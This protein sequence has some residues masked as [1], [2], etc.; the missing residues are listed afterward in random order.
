MAIRDVAWNTVED[1]LSS[2]EATGY[3]LGY[4][5]TPV[6]VDRAISNLDMYNFLLGSIRREDEKD[7]ELLKRLF[8]GLQ[9]V[10][11]TNQRKRESVKTLWDINT[12][13]NKYLTYMKNIVGW[14]PQYKYITDSLE[15]LDLRR[16][17]SLSVPLWKKRGPEAAILSLL[18]L[19]TGS[20]TRMFNWFD[21]RWVLGE[22]ESGVERLGTD[23]WIIDNPGTNSSEYYSNLRIVDDGSLDH[24][25]VREAVNL[26]RACGERI[27]VTYV[28]FMDLFEV[29]DDTSQ[30]IIDDPTYIN[31]II[32]VENGTM[33][34]PSADL[35]Y[36]G[37]GAKSLRVTYNGVTEPYAYQEPLFDGKSYRITGKARG[38]GTANPFIENGAG[39]TLWTG[40]SSVVWQSF[41][42]SFK[43]LA[44][45][46]RFVG[47]ST[48][49]GHVEF[50][51]VKIVYDDVILEDGNFERANSLLEDGDM[52]ADPGSDLV[53]NGNFSGWADSTVP[54]GWTKSGTHDANNYVEESSGGCR[55]VS[56]GTGISI[57]QSVVTV[58]KN[59]EITYDVVDVTSG[60]AKIQWGSSDPDKF[61]I[62]S[63]GSFK[64]NFT[65]N[66]I[67][68]YFA[69][70][71]ACDVT[72]DNLVIQE[73]AQAWTANDAAL[74]S[75]QNS[76]PKV[77]LRN[78]RVTY[79]GTFAPSASQDLL[80]VGVKYKL[81]GYYRG[82]G[83]SAIPRVRCGAPY[84][85]IGTSSNTWQAF[86]VTFVAEGDN[87][88]LYNY[89]S[90]G[91]TEFDDLELTLVDESLLFDH[92]M[93]REWGILEDGDCESLNT[94]SWSSSS[95]TLSK[96]TTDPK[97][98]RR[99]LRVTP[100]S[101]S[102]GRAKQNILISGKTYR[103][104]GWARTD[105]TATKKAAIS[106]NG[107]SN[108]VWEGT[109]AITTWEYFD[110]LFIAET[111]EIGF[112]AL[113][114]SAGYT[115]FDDLKVEYL[116]D[117]NIT[118]ADMEGTGSDVIK[119][120]DMEDFGLDIIS[121]GDMEDTGS[122]L[123]SDGN[124]EKIGTNI[125]L[126]GDMENRTDVIVDG[127]MENGPGSDVITNG[128]FAN[129]TGDDPDNWTVVG[130]TGTSYITENSPLGAQ[131]VSDG[132]NINMIQTAVMTVGK[133]Y[134]ISFDITQSNSGS[135]RLEDDGAAGTIWSGIS[136]VQTYS[137]KY[138]AKG[139]GIRFIRHVACD[140]TVDNLV[141]KES[142][143]DWTAGNSAKLTKEI[144]NPE[145]GTQC[146]KIEYNGSSSP[147]AN[148]NVLI[149]SKVFRIKGYARS[150]GTAIPAISANGFPDV[151]V[152]TNSVNWQYFEFDVT[153]TGNFLALENNSSSGYV[154]FDSVVVIDQAASCSNWTAGSGAVLTKEITN[155]QN[156]KQ[157]LRVTDSGSVGRAY[158]AVLVAGKTYRIKGYARS[159][160]TAT[161]T[162]EVGGIVGN[163]WTGTTSTS[164]QAFDFLVVAQ[165][166][167]LFL[168]K[169][170]GTGVYVEFD[171]VQAIESELIDGDMEKTGT[172]LITDGDMEAGPGSEEFTDG[173]MEAVGFTNWTVSQ[174]TGSKETSS[175]YEGS[176]WAKLTATSG[177]G[178]R[179]PQMYQGAL[180]IGKVYRVTGV[181]K[182]DGTQMARVTNA[183]GG[184][185]EDITSGTS[186]TPFDFVFLATSVSVAL[187]FVVTDPAG[188]EYVGYDD[189]SVVETCPDWIDGN[190]SLLTKETTTPYEG[191]QC[192]RIPYNGITNPFA[193]QVA[194]V[195]S[196]VY[197]VKGVVRSDGTT[198][199]RVQTGATILFTGTTS[200]SW[201]PFDVVFVAASVNFGLWAYGSSGYAEF[202]AIELF[203]GANAVSDWTPINNA[204]LT[205][206]VTSPQAGDQWLKIANSGTANPDAQ[207]SILTVGEVYRIKGYFKGDGTALPR[208]IQG[209]NI[210]ATG[211]TSTSWQSF[212]A[213][214]VAAVDTN[215]NFQARATVSPG[216]SVGFDSI[217]LINE[218]DSCSDWTVVNSAILSKQDSTPYEGERT[219]RMTYN[220]STSPGAEQSILTIGK[221]YRVKGVM[222]SSGV[223]TPSVRDLG[224]AIWNGT[225]STSW[226][227]FDVVF[228]AA[229]NWLRLQ[230]IGSSG[231]VEADN[232][233]VIDESESCDDWTVGNS[234]LLSKQEDPYS[235]SK[236]LRIEYDGSGYPNAYQLVM[237]VDKTYR[238][239][240]YYRGDGSSAQPR[241]YDT[242]A[243]A[244]EIVSGSFGSTWEAFDV[245]WKAKSTKLEFRN[246]SVVAGYVEFDAI[247]I[248]DESQSCVEWGLGNSALL[249]KQEDPYEGSQVLRVEYGGSSFPYAK[250]DIVTIDKTYRVRG[251]ARGDGTAL[252]KILLQDTTELFLGT[253]STSW[254]PF[255][256]V[257]KTSSTQAIFFRANT[258]SDSY[259]EFDAVEVIDESE[260]CDD[261]IV[262]NDAL[263][264]KEVTDPYGGSQNLKIAYNNESKPYA[265]SVDSI[266]S[267][268]ICR[269][270][271][272]FRTGGSGNAQIWSA[273][274]AVNWSV[275]DSAGN[276]EWND[277]IYGN[278]IFV[279]VSRTSNKVATS[280]D[281]I[282]WTL[283]TGATEL[284]WTDVAYGNGTFVAVA[285]SGTNNRVMTS[286][287]GISWTSRTSAA[288]NYW[289]SVTYG[290]GIFVAVAS[291]GTGNR[292]MTSIDGTTWISR[293]AA[294]DNDWESVTF[295]N[296]LFVAVSTN[297]SSNR[298][299]TSTNGTSWTSRTSAA[300]NGWYSV[301]YGNG[302]YVAV[303]SSGTGNRVMTSIDGTTWISRNA[304]VDN[305]WNDVAYGNGL[306]VAV[307]RTGT[308]DRMMSSVD[309]TT[310][311]TRKNSVDGD[312]RGV[313]YGNGTFVTVAGD[314]SDNI[315]MVSEAKLVAETS[316]STWTE[317]DEEFTSRNN[318]IFMSDV[319][320]AGYAEF[321]EVVLKNINNDYDIILDG[322]F[323]R[324]GTIL[325]DGDLEDSGISDWTVTDCA[326]TKE[327][328][329]PYRGTRY[330]RL[331]YNGTSSG[332]IY[333]DLLKF[334]QN[335]RIK[336]VARGDGVSNPR[337]SDGVTVLWTGT[338]STNWQKFNIPFYKAVLVNYLLFQGLNLGTGNYVEFDDLELISEETNVLEDGDMELSDTTK[339]GSSSATL[340]KNAT[341]HT[342][343]YCLRIYRTGGTLGSAYAFQQ[344]LVNGARYRVTGWARGNTLTNPSVRCDPGTTLW[345]GTS[346]Q[347][348]QYFDEIFVADSVVL[349]FYK[350]QHATDLTG[351]VEFDNIVVTQVGY[352]MEW[353]V[354]GSGV[355]LSKKD[356]DIIDSTQCL[357]I[358]TTTATG[359]ASQKIF[360][361]GQ[362]YRVRG[363]A[364][365]DGTAIPSVSAVGTGSSE[366]VGD[367]STSWQEFDFLTKAEDSELQLINSSTSGYVE[368]DKI[369]VDVINNKIENGDFTNWTDPTVPDDWD[370]S[371][372]HD[373]NNYVI[374]SSG[375]CRVV[376]DGTGVGIKQDVLVSGK[377]YILTWDVTDITTDG[378]KWS[379]PGGEL[380]FT[381]EG[382]KKAIIK[383]TGTSLT[384]YRRAV[385]V[386]ADFTIDNVILYEL[387]DSVDWT[388]GNN[389]ILTKQKFDAIN[390]SQ[391]IKVQYGGTS[392]PDAVQFILT[393]GE[394]YRVTG[395]YRCDGTHK[396]QV[397]HGINLI[398]ETLNTSWTY[399]DE[400]FTS[401]SSYLALFCNTSVSGGWAEFDDIKVI[402]L[403]F[404]MN[405][406]S[407]NDATITKEFS[408]PYEGIQNLKVAY[409]GTAN[410][411]AY[412][413]K[414]FIT[415]KQYR[416]R[417]YFRGDGSS[418]YAQILWGNQGS[419][420]LITQST[421]SNTWQY[422]DKTFT[423]TTSGHNELQLKVPISA[424]GY[425]EFD[426]IQV[427][428]LDPIIEDGDM[429]APGVDVIIDGDMEAV[430][431]AAWT[432]I[433]SVLTK[434]TTEP[435]EGSQCLRVTYSSSGTQRAEQQVTTI[436][437]TY[438]I[439]GVAR[440][441]GIHLPK[442]YENGVSL[443]TGNT[444]TS[445]Q[446]FDVIIRAAYTP[447][448]I[449]LG[450]SLS[451]G[452]VEFDDV[453]IIDTAPAWDS[454]H[455]AILTKSVNVLANSVAINHL[456][457]PNASV[458]ENYLVSTK[459][460]AGFSAT[461]TDRRWGIYLYQD[462]SSVVGGYWA[463]F[464]ILNN[465]VHLGY[466]DDPAGVT[467]N[468][469]DT[470]GMR[471]AKDVY[472]GINIEIQRVI[473]SSIQYII[474]NLFIDG[475][476]I[477]TWKDVAQAIRGRIAFFNYDLDLT[478]EDVEVAKMPIVVETIDINS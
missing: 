399:F 437:K 310:W 26:M 287:D 245:V 220:A 155:P 30:W 281:G 315:I 64:Y 336:G 305:N 453:K 432:A 381:T 97:I 264:S 323:D 295:G 20:R 254:Q 54:D 109:E 218:T 137:T 42:V 339:W 5:E 253:T 111:A 225:T 4:S 398:T 210:L 464:D 261:L 223:M 385:S 250:Q 368:F 415:N 90:A 378:G 222:R 100:S 273:S 200:T 19:V 316:N 365:S 412:Q 269:V 169:D 67:D 212:D 392:R 340:E 148:Q 75:K 395:Y 450:S 301:T 228:V 456:V 478:I 159:D 344:E 21:F 362:Y 154:E 257:F 469:L 83:S 55:L 186:W 202:D 158:Q 182:S 393:N 10:W 422:F 65:A 205:K 94:T 50:D 38:D 364:R 66:R 306:F 190:S 74:L 195:V 101:S 47:S 394:K 6:S 377:I 407:Y 268:K 410:P 256:V 104:T 267:G 382:S 366:W 105:G 435:Y 420:T 311:T 367:T 198:I 266:P 184:L 452:Y 230:G 221:T 408:D 383:P 240:G 322:N 206:E 380:P 454:D 430:G 37:E 185:S 84:I 284:L 304:A 421:T 462:Q 60:S 349:R 463:I 224:T 62:N 288:D 141:I 46:I 106:P 423:P 294:V 374:E 9:K 120:G 345:T 442:V 370:K 144:I 203:D 335:Y 425:A 63:T 33:K 351:Y 86:D 15:P 152:G 183:G 87:I 29:N 14:T 270:K 474:I 476:K 396:A 445:W 259:V 146:L 3:M 78:L 465:E 231:Y 354:A 337:I 333:Q 139:T 45:E 40:T 133:T 12:I 177:A 402:P 217:E 328:G 196:N 229:T 216:D 41:D 61:I 132:S 192:L 118:D 115:E 53:T 314:S 95:A 401:A 235:G 122:D 319:S 51:D 143:P 302:L 248:I 468:T 427:E 34:I 151:W 39:T 369:Q 174:A 293:N 405:W 214:F 31:S 397:Q 145:N 391:S 117:N 246:Q 125:V 429:E 334:G 440:S 376:S 22:T 130:E 164:W 252:P 72:I 279:A 283:R 188:T 149:A 372:T 317:F 176:Q 320:A 165:G 324:K 309:G 417:G 444:S 82:D 371:G 471:L 387:P 96:Q 249:S 286:T 128:D 32:T 116:G 275:R 163:L 296:D 43:S 170:P 373:V 386:A 167:N 140:V 473:E 85:S 330:V 424:S 414:V 441:D 434:E 80:T 461:G 28:S 112:H 251:V 357:R 439:T 390:G 142:C 17:I 23:P 449:Q 99:Y 49:A 292:V 438:R 98:G 298:V 460:K 89:S 93:E 119:D 189:V 36:S 162:V 243:G 48:A 477:A 255:D 271:G 291:S 307:A 127:D 443:W 285:R 265:I 157:C 359:T 1:P 209:G 70:N 161:P 413:D 239:R 459:T 416:I 147:Y 326:L 197:R 129:W 446:P 52:E 312:F 363:L 260:S 419:G 103:I 178:T 458:W 455:S 258:A 108:Y 126:D 242:G 24:R 300:D 79:G 384:L 156:G 244:Y 280:T 433:A 91:Y 290:N 342:G 2:V 451:G 325:K 168:E 180:T 57:F 403:G 138:V 348:W 153:P 44:K 135:I 11:D 263:L 201:Q 329:S 173:D 114:T 237:V 213:V 131:I 409:N 18:R 274:D 241:I 358:T 8:T 150:D 411:I 56:D 191:T 321:D 406:V 7:T 175:P 313:A 58:G 428:L 308:K 431:V 194:T 238:I 457:I 327:T 211:T 272:H 247:E 343:N 331:T 232:V 102:N 297:G 68:I 69:K 124:M 160:G 341:S 346:S 73:V 277:V 171:S 470:F 77:G 303:A 299:M 404:V 110:V 166:A 81:T 400:V 113:N 226:Q 208:I 207:Q 388:V 276:Y 318:L 375:K 193:Y 181:A 356:S 361:V 350:D 234:A 136:A 472:Y 447:S 179:Y 475:V 338:N 35:D 289:N 204:T 236:C 107:V 121:D 76:D 347:D 426:L 134:D 25:L 389:A 92:D 379:F 187:T 353:V 352:L 59:Y 71:V 278:G 262:G 360:E 27:E 13:E 436:G 215:I 466:G 219:L 332:F 418:A 16:L 123:I 467:V 199:P 282:S 88:G 448:K 172:D 233:E 355:T 227:P